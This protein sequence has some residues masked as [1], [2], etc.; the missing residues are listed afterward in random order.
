MG[1]LH[2]ISARHAGSFDCLMTSFTLITMDNGRGHC[3][4]WQACQ[5]PNQT[6]RGIK[7]KTYAKKWI[8]IC[9]EYL[10]CYPHVCFMHDASEFS[11]IQSPIR[12]TEWS[13]SWSSKSLFVLKK[14]KNNSGGLSCI[15]WYIN[16]PVRYALV[17]VIVNIL[18]ACIN[19]SVW[20]L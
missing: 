14:M 3:A 15:N 4:G 20:V 11:D 12:N 1:Q 8:K 10:A 17:S 6:P 19:D 9:A 7:R 16:F 18:L 5:G 2:L 13:V